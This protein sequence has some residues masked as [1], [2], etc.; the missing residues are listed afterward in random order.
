M[1]SPPSGPAECAEGARAWVLPLPKITRRRVVIAAAFA[2]LLASNWDSIRK[3]RAVL[4]PPEQ[5]VAAPDDAREASPE[6]CAARFEDLPPG[7]TLLDL[8][9]K[10]G[11]TPFPVRLR[12]SK[13][14]M[15]EVTLTFRAGPKGKGPVIQCEDGSRY[16]IANTLKWEGLDFGR[17]SLHLG[18]VA[19]R[20]DRTVTLGTRTSGFQ[21]ESVEID[22]DELVKMGTRLHCGEDG[23]VVCVGFERKGKEQWK[24]AE[25]IVFIREK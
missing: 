11:F 13:P 21:E 17:A 25:S 9:P 20:D 5:A 10:A 1:R 12:G 2:A 23:A 16:S 14:E 6:R 4:N 18:S 15:G 19:K 8:D 3:S 7:T 22:T 24:S